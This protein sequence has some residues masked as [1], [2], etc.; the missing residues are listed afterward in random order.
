[1][2]QSI[3]ETLRLRNGAAEFGNIGTG[4]ANDLI[5][6][7]RLFNPYDRV[8]VHRS[9]IDTDA[10]ELANDFTIKATM[11]IAN[12]TI[13]LTTA[14]SGT[15]DSAITTDAVS[16]Y[17]SDEP[18]CETKVKLTSIADMQFYFGFIK[19]ANELCYLIFDPAVSANWYLAVNGGGTTSTTD[20]GIPVVAATYY[21]IG[22]G[23]DTAGKPYAIIDNKL[24]EPV[25]ANATTSNRASADAM[26]MS[27]LVVES[28]AA[29][30]V[31]T[32]KYLAWSFNK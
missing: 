6:A 15:D 21:K 30:K 9:F 10:T 19:D 29:A 8:G 2:T 20:T 11:A 27:A 4:S 17:R 24:V 31:A 23:C 26:Y 7:G 14:G 16:F 32:L 5:C 13:T 3:L 25:S 18:Y 28:T 1:M 22:V 12:N